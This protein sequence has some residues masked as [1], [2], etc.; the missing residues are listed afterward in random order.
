M[1]FQ[2]ANGAGSSSSSAVARVAAAAGLDLAEVAAAF[3]AETVLIALAMIVAVIALGA[4][5]AVC[6]IRLGRRLMPSSRLLT[7]PRLEGEEEEEDDDEDD[8]EEEVSAKNGSRM[9]RLGE[10]LGGKR[11][12]GHSKLRTSAADVEG[13]P[14]PVE[15][16]LPGEALYPSVDDDRVM[17]D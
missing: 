13:E 12:K 4:C 11:R 5:V 10:Q 2:D 14:L 1:S 6:W 17:L 16:A 8:E 7:P 15:I 9:H 3:D